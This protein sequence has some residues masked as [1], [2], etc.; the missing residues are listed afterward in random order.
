M[1]IDMKKAIQKVACFVGLLMAASASFAT[2]SACNAQAGNLVANC[3]FESG[4]F[5]GWTVSGNDVPGEQGNLYGVE[6]GA[7]PFDGMSPH[8]G[9]NQAYFADLVSNASTLSQNLATQAGKNYVI[10]FY[11]AQDT[12]PGTGEG[13]NSLDVMFG[14]T[15]L[16]NVSNVAVEG[17]TEYSFLASATSSST[18]LKLTLGNG[19][20]E[21][22]LDDVSVVAAATVP[23]PSSIAVIG[24]GMLAMLYAVRRRQR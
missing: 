1:E 3:G 5:T 22:L 14:G 15:T 13:S 20:G 19:L 8:S 2:S 7:D 18:S 21:F 23:E 11:L 6:Q 24:I 10:S 16:E 9:N 4:D 12:T 17:Y